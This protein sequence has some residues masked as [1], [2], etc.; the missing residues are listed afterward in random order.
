M[1]VGGR[2]RPPSVGLECGNAEEAI[3]RD[4]KGGGD[5]EEMRDALLWR[6][7][8]KVERW[9]KGV[10]CV[11]SRASFDRRRRVHRLEI[12]GAHLR[13]R[14]I[15]VIWDY[16]RK[17]GRW[18]P[19]YLLS[20][21]SNCES[22]HEHRNEWRVLRW[23]RW[24]VLSSDADEAFPERRPGPPIPAPVHIGT[25]P[26]TQ[27]STAVSLSIFEA[28]SASSLLFPAP[29][30]SA[31]LAYRPSVQRI[32]SLVSVGA[33]LR[34]SG[35]YASTRL[36][37]STTSFLDLYFSTHAAAAKWSEHAVW[38]KIPIGTKMPDLPILLIARFV[39]IGER[40]APIGPARALRVPKQCS[41]VSSYTSY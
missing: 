20:I 23:F 24:R 13:I 12:L 36:L 37:S 2:P 18:L 19:I 7:F 28:H 35:V 5:G 30:G 31:P 6:L 16:V 15:S 33:A 10:V 26:A 22:Y 9:C 3:H 8:V 29:N 38:S 41:V 32:S 25:A 34:T 21:Q 4:R 14:R 11:R 17:R 27:L 39:L 40:S 1:D